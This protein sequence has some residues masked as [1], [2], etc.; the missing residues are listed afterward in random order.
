LV[1]LATEGARCT[2]VAGG[3]VAATPA[4]A[5]RNPA[6]LALLG[7]RRGLPAGT[8]A[9]AVHAALN[10]PVNEHGELPIHTVLR[11]ADP[12][13]ELV[14][15]MLDAG[16]DAMLAV[17]DRSKMLPLHHAARN[18][19]S[20]AMVALLLA[21]GPAG[22]ART[23]NANGRTPLACAEHYN[24]GPA[25][26]EIKALL[27]AAMREARLLRLLGLPA[28]TAAPAI[29]AAHNEPAGSGNLPSHCALVGAGVGAL[30]DTVTDPELVGAMLDAGGEAMLAVP[31]RFKFLPLHY[32]ARN[33]RSPAVVA[34][35]LARGPAGSTRAEATSGRTPLACAEVYN[36][37]P[38]AAEIKALLQAAMQ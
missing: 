31:G 7:G 23:E 37:G 19:S 1:L 15:A 20:P 25:A 29:R 3:Q 38:A 21:R 18:S 27:R 9:A 26:E 14:R 10:E 6:L 11:D 12:D 33:S 8:P 13:P 36:K 4:Q 32:A 22:S 24:T 16:G 17:P 2:E 5:A 34:L 35:L 28:G 30:I